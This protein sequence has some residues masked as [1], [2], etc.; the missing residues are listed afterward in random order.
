MEE[1][2]DEEEEERESATARRRGS[3]GFFVVEDLNLDTA[4]GATGC[5]SGAWLGLREGLL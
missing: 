5:V 4:L 1:K 3:G 2:E